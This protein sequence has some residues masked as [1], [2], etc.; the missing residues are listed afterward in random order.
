MFFLYGC[1]LLAAALPASAQFKAWVVAKL[2][3]T[4]QGMAVDSKGN[5]YTLFFTPAK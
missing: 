3:D 1:A 4:P 5:L 2:P